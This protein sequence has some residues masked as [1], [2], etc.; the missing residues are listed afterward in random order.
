MQE[1]FEASATDMALAT[2][3]FASVR[4]LGG[5]VTVIRSGTGLIMGMIG[6]GS[7]GSPH[8]I[9]QIGQYRLGID[10]VILYGP[11]IRATM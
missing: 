6:R 5:K 11:I 4:G 1:R 8:T 9:D 7:Y 2:S 10:P 3:I